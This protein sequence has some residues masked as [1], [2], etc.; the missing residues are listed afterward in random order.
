M[1]NNVEQIQFVMKQKLKAKSGGAPKDAEF[2]VTMTVSRRNANSDWLI[3]RA[4]VVPKP[5]D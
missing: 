5:K 2:D 3:D 1:R 4:D